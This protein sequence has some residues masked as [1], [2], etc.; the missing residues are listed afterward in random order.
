MFLKIPQLHRYLVLRIR[1]VYP[2]SRIRIFSIPD[3]GYRVEKIPDPGS[4]TASKNLSILTQKLFLNSWKY[5]PGCSSRIRILIVYPSRIPDPGV[6]RHRTPDPQ[7][8]RY[9][10]FIVLCLIRVGTSPAFHFILLTLYSYLVLGQLGIP[11]FPWPES[12]AHFH[13]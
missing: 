2:G 10:V 1:D 9:L 4:G 6:K 12:L 11:Q 7:H 5:Y 13:C 3:P 8:C